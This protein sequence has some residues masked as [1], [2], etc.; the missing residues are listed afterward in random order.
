MEQRLRN[1]QP[2]QHPPLITR[3]S[4]KIRLLL[5]RIFNA[6]EHESEIDTTSGCEVA[7]SLHH[8]FD[9]CRK[10]M[11]RF[12]AIL[13][14]SRFITVFDI[15]GQALKDLTS[16]LTS[17]SFSDIRTHHLTLEAI[18]IREPTG[19]EMYSIPLSFCKTWGDFQKV[20]Y[21]CFKDTKAVKYIYQGKWAIVPEGDNTIID[22]TSSTSLL[23][24]GKRFD[25]GVIVELLSARTSRTCPQCGHY[26]KDSTPVAGWIQCTDIECQK[27]F[28]IFFDP[29]FKVSKE[30]R[31]ERDV[32]RQKND[33]RHRNA[34][35]DKGRNV[36]PVEVEMIQSTDIREIRLPEESPYPRTKF[37][38][39][40]AKVPGNNDRPFCIIVMVSS[41]LSCF[42]PYPPWIILT[43]RA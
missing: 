25:I 42:M 2:H 35:E 21:Q 43:G 14:A 31:V 15:R 10:E 4:G 34:P 30:N 28:R 13:I 3:K 1:I 7:Q 32:R 11:I 36:T 12:L 8:H 23:K 22:Q 18:W 24:P 33:G 20:I 17:A 29:L 6:C 27:Q 16:S 9:I 37:N 40:L 19:I 26:N 39:I 5:L 41:R 38:R